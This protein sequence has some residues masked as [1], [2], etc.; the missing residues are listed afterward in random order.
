MRRSLF[1]AVLFTAL[2]AA[3][4]EGG[5]TDGAEGSEQGRGGYQ[6]PSGSGRFSIALNWGASIPVG[7]QPPLGGN[8]VTGAPMY[9]GGTASLWMYDWFLLDAHGSY[10]FNTGRTHILVGPRFRTS[11]WPVA[12]SLGLRAG[13]ILDPQ[14]GLRFGLSPIGTLEMIFLKHLL[15]GLEGSFDIPLAGNGSALRV[16]LNLGW[17][18]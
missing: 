12:A 1:V 14:I 5:R 11:T 7:V 6:K 9:L 17:R 16:G 4:Q 8:G 13:A 15:V 18:F 3:A 2:A 10:A